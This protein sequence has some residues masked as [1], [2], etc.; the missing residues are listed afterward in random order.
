MGSHYGF[1]EKGVIFST[2]QP[3]LATIIIYRNGDVVLKTWIEEDYKDYDKILHLRQNGVPLTEWDD[4]KSEP[5]VGKFVTKWGQGN[6]SGSQDQNQEVLELEFAK[7]LM[8]IR[9]S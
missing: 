5:V 6:W 4:E 1:A 9:I 8:A 7:L 3:G 2:P